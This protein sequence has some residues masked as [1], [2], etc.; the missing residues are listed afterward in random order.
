LDGTTP[1]T[2]SFLYTG[3]FTLTNSAGVTAIAIQPGA[4]NSP[5]ANASFINSSAIGNGDGLTGQY[6]ANTLSTAFTNIGFTNLPTL[7]RTDVVVNFNWGSSGPSPGIGATNYV[8]RW[9][10]TLQPQFSELYTFSTTADDGVRLF[11]NGQ[12]IIDD[13]NNQVPFTQSNSIP[14]V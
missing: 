1:T 9:T 7:V 5:A 6:W 10:G 14:L 8:V 12:L 2:N 3:P 13:W 11:I 4:F